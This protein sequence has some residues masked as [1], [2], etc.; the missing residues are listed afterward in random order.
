MLYI[1]LQSMGDWVNIYIFVSYAHEMR[2]K[3]AGAYAPA[4]LYKAH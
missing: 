2:L 4:F 3:K 1:L